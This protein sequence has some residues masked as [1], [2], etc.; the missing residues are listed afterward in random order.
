MA[1]LSLSEKS[2]GW[3]LFPERRGEDAAGGADTASEPQAG[4]AWHT[5]RAVRLATRAGVVRVHRDHGRRTHAHLDGHQRGK[6]RARVAL[7][8][9]GFRRGHGR[10]HPGV[11]GGALLQPRQRGRGR[12]AV[13]WALTANG[14]IYL[15]HPLAWYARRAGNSAAAWSLIMAFAPGRGVHGPRR[16]GRHEPDSEQ[17]HRGSTSAR[18][19]GSRARSPTSRG[20]R[21][22]VRGR[23]HRGWCTP[24]G[25]PSW[26]AKRR[27]RTVEG[28]GSGSGSNAMS[29]RR[30]PPTWWPVALLSTCFA[31]LL[32]RMAAKMPRSLDA[33]RGR[34]RGKSM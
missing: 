26:R 12:P 31:S 25:Q 28:G 15:A 5:D 23:A 2:R 1:L 29:R 27:R 13:R 30:M 7:I 11:R 16:D 19:T 33:P 4:A 34:R 10:H 14:I 18:S 32:S 21:A 24:R 9:I 3:T 17:L 20:R 8:D 6:R 22:R